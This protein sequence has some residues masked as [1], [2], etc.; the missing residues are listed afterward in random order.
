MKQN[1]NSQSRGKCIINTEKG[2]VP[3]KMS[4]KEKKRKNTKN[5]MNILKENRKLVGM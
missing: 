3:H 5:C 2:T 4:F 1:S